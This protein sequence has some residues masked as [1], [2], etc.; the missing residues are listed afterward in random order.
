MEEREV[1]YCEKCGFELTQ[2]ASAEFCGNR[3][4]EVNREFEE[5]WTKE[6]CLT[7]GAHKT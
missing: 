2:H 6:T 3:F 4:C 5:A 7:C 1:A